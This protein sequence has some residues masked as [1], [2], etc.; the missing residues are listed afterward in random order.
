[1]YNDLEEVGE[2]E[3]INERFKLSYKNIK[4]YFKIYKK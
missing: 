1:M 3:E 4:L 2:K